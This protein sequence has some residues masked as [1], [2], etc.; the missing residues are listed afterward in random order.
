ME[1]HRLGCTRGPPTPV[2][3]VVTRGLRLHRLVTLARTRPISASPTAATQGRAKFVCCVKLWLSITLSV[4]RRARA[5]LV[6]VLRQESVT[7]KI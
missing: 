5:W 2:E 3:Q 6:C 4:A 7:H 1:E